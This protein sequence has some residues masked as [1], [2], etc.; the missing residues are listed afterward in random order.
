MRKPR[1]GINGVLK[2]FNGDPDANCLSLCKYDKFKGV[3]KI[4][5]LTYLIG[6]DF[7]FVEE[8][9]FRIALLLLSFYRVAKKK[10]QSYIN[11]YGKR[12]QEFG[13]FLFTSEMRKIVRAFYGEELCQ[14]VELNQFTK[15]ASLRKL[16]IEDNLQISIEI[17]KIPAL[18]QLL[19]GLHG[20]KLYLNHDSS[21]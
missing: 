14:E 13:T 6:K 2:S 10:K 18:R 4:P 1:G 12:I 20:R 19:E 3:T 5:V 17:V 8:G 16:L 21:S 7:N 11:V 15:Y 9:T